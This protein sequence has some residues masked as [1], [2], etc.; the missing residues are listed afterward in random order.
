M[1]HVNKLSPLEWHRE[2]TRKSIHIGLGLFLTIVLSVTSIPLFQFFLTGIL[3]AGIFLALIAHARIFPVLEDV[4][5]EVHR[6]K[7]LFPGESAFVFVLGVLLPTFFFT[8]P[9]VIML[10]IL[11]LTFQDGFSTLVGKKYGRIHLRPNKTVEG[12][13]AGFAAAFVV[14]LALIPVEQA[15]LLAL[16]VT[17]VELI[18]LND[19]FSIPAFTAVAASLLV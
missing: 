15:F 2:L 1:V 10:G 14:F 6:P 7:E 5:T 12:S 16:F 13:L 17:L 19:S 3:V 11:G 18:P 4:L 8:D 9:F